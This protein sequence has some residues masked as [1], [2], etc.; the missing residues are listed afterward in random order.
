MVE[1]LENIEVDSWDITPQSAED[2]VGWLCSSLANGGSSR[3]YGVIKRVELF[4]G[5]IYKFWAFWTDDEES[6]EKR[7][8]DYKKDDYLSY[9]RRYISDI[10]FIKY[11]GL[12]EDKKAWDL[13]TSN[14][15]YYKTKHVD[16]YFNVGYCRCKHICIL[17]HTP[18]GEPIESVF[19]LWSDSPKHAEEL[20]VKYDMESREYSAEFLEKVDNGNKYEFYNASRALGFYGMPGEFGWM[21]LS[22]LKILEDDVKQSWDISEDKGNVEDLARGDVIKVYDTTMKEPYYILFLATDYVGDPPGIIGIFGNDIEEIEAIFNAFNSHEV[23]DMIDDP[24][25]FNDEKG[26]E[27]VGW[28]PIAEIT[29]EGR[30]FE[31]ITHMES[32]AWDIPPTEPPEI[33]VAGDRV[34]LLDCKEGNRNWDLIGLMPVGTEGTVVVGNT[35]GSLYARTLLKVKWDGINRVVY[36]GKKD[37]EF[38]SHKESW[39]IPLDSERFVAGDRVKLLDCEKDARTWGGFTLEPGIMGTVIDTFDFSLIDESYRATVKWDRED[40]PFNCAVKLDNI[41]FVSSKETWDIAYQPTLW[42]W[43][44]SI[45]DPLSGCGVEVYNDGKSV[46][47]I[48]SWEYDHDY[49]KYVEKA[50][51]LY[52]KYIT[53][54]VKDE[55]EKHS[56]MDNF[57]FRNIIAQYHPEF[58]QNAAGICVSNVSLDT[59]KTDEE[60]IKSSWDI[61]ALPKSSIVNDINELLNVIQSGQIWNGKT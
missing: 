5:D 41:E 59:L 22:D 44:S 58:N 24:D 35:G 25:G 10:N 50:K 3:Y 43:G 8:R 30:N 56:I 23:D 6:A 4:E 33:Y 47:A 14:M 57:L 15:Y 38:I 26:F 60:F 29:G 31:K 48:W 27:V 49:D 37:V 45:N 61:P 2:A 46:W 12:G 17:S 55:L 32:M 36:V 53:Q 54:D 9:V 40:M 28:T 16:Q 42:W 21:N 20:W 19:G 51:I 34:R 11:V 7:F 1:E 39:D 18:L 52:N 13:S